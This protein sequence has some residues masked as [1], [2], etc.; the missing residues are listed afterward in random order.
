MTDEILI[1]ACDLRK[2]IEYVERFAEGL[3]FNRAIKV[4]VPEK[5]SIKFIFGQGSLEREYKLPEALR[6]KLWEDVCEYLNKL[7]REYKELGI[8]KEGK[9]E[10][11]K[12]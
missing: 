2:E 4:K 1:K 3:R 9:D 12:D 8:E 10:Q 5:K 11:E 7:R 6:E